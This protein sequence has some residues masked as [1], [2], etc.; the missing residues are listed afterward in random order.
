MSS[1]RSSP[2]AVAHNGSGRGTRPR[3]DRRT[4]G[5]GA[6]GS[7][8]SV[9]PSPA[10]RRTSGVWSSA[11]LDGWIEAEERAECREVAA[12]ALEEASDVGPLEDMPVVGPQ[13]LAEERRAGQAQADQ[14]AALVGHDEEPDERFGRVD[15]RPAAAQ[16]LVAGRPSTRS[17]RGRRPGRGRTRG[18]RSRRAPPGSPGRRAAGRRAARAPRAG[19]RPGRPR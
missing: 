8:R 17:R 4:R 12:P 7:R 1:N 10:A 11:S 2:C 19:R 15:A 6:A 14:L 16:R 3:R 18:S 5:P 9:H 13:P